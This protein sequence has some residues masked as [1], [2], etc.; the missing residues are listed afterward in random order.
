MTTFRIGQIVPS[1]NT[2]METE[3]PAMLWHGKQ[4]GLSS[5]YSIRAGCACRDSRRKSLLEWMRSRI[6]ALRNSVVHTSMFLAMR[7]LSPLWPG[8]RL[9]STIEARLRQQTRAHGVPQ[10]APVG[11]KSSSGNIFDRR[12]L[13]PQSGHSLIRTVGCLLHA[14]IGL[15]RCRR[16]IEVTASDATANTCCTFTTLIGCT[17]RG[18][19]GRPRSSIT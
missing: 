14:A 17:V 2:T 4:S 18:L 10:R 1:S 3:I 6:D 9:P 11:W 8:P 5:S 13:V 7:A 15:V 16:N 19:C 12:R